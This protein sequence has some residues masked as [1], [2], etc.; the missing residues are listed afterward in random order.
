M[1]SEFRSKYGLYHPVQFLNQ[2]LHGK[3]KPL[4]EN[5]KYKGHIGVSVNTWRWRK[6]KATIGLSR[7]SESS[8]KKSL[9]E[10]HFYKLFCNLYP[11]TPSSARLHG[12]LISSSH[13]INRPFMSQVSVWGMHFLIQS[14][15]DSSNQILYIPLALL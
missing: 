15:V 13:E 12:G 3:G 14:G 7:L 8:S 1:S 11:L 2:I 10:G 6:S 5:N 9:K 4:N